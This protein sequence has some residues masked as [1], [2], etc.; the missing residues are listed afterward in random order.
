MAKVDKS[1]Y[2][3]SEWRVLRE[4]RRRAKSHEKS[5][6]FVSPESTEYNIVCVKQG[7]KY[8]ANYVNVLYN[9][10]QR[11]TTLPHKFVC[12]TDNTQDLK[13]EINTVAL[14]PELRG[15]WAKPYVFSNDLGLNGRILYLDLDVVIAGNL[16]KLLMHSP[17]H[18]HIIRDF[19]RVFRPNW[20]RYNSSVIKFSA[21]QLDDLW[22][23]FR[24][25]RLEYQKQ[26]YGDQD[27]LYAK[28]TPRAR[29]WPESW[30]L[31]WKWEVRK[32]RQY[33]AGGR[34]GNRKFRDTESVEPRAECAV[35]V[36]HG[37]PNPE[38]VDD[39]WVIKNWR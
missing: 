9:M 18:W 5:N 17:Q 29:F 4:Q 22:Q 35:T 38:L 32:S 30:I 28:A 7:N 12:V 8:S 13:S 15:W 3:K 27:W 14:P 33:A 16:D 6:R 36:F 39:P 21:G 2:T 24:D 31:S 1:Q 10:V 25:N 37:D 34:K 23:D 26:F 19:T 20:K 11:N